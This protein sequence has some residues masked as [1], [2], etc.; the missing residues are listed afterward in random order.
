MPFSDS[1]LRALKA[2]PKRMVVGAGNSLFVV[3]ESVGKGGGKSFIGRTRFPP[4]RSGKQVEVRIG[5]YGKGAGKWTLKAARE[6]WE[7]IRTWSK[8]TGRDPREMKKGADQGPSKTLDDAIQG[9]LSTKTSLK[10]FTLT[11]YR[12]Q[13]ENQVTEVIPATTP[14]R[15][16]EWD[17]GGREKVRALRTH[18]EDRGSYDQAFRVQKVLAQALDYAI[19]QGW[20]RRNQNP[21]TKQK[22]EESKHDPKHHPHIQWEQVPEL[23]EAINLNR[24]SGHVQSVMALKFLLMTFLRAG[25]LARLEWKWIN[26][27]ENLLVIPGTT[28]GLKRTKKTEDLPHHVPLTKEMNALLK[29]AKQMNGHLPYVFGPVREHSRYPHLDPESPNNLLKGLRYR[30]VLRAHGWRSL[31]L[32]AGQE[33]LK[34]PHDIIQRQMGHLIGDKV[35][36]AYDKSLMLEER[37]DF[38]EQWCKLLVKN[39]LKI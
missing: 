20:M 32:T 17:N 38:L 6:E 18:I 35:R 23:L 1:D 19:L 30:E 29:Q 11:N 14:L 25:A 36:K 5:P 37:R 31:P 9:F 34:A 33:V 7:R 15:E 24:C 12:R 10:E 39:G 4:G 13:L 27:K 8:D 2:G 21:A 22:G 16:L 26:R 3:V 28:P